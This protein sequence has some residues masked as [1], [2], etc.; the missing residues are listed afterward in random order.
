MGVDLQIEKHR[1]LYLFRPSRLI[2]YEK[3]AM[4]QNLLVPAFGIRADLTQHIHFEEIVAEVEE[5]NVGEGR[6]K[7]ESWSRQ[8][9]LLLQDILPGDLI[10]V[11][12]RNGCYGIAMARPECGLTEDGETGRKVEWL[13]RE[14]RKGVFRPDLEHS[15]GAQQSV[16][17]ITR[18]DAASR[19]MA[20]ISNGADPGP[21]AESLNADMSA[22]SI[23][24]YARMQMLAKIRTAFAGHGLAELVAALL[25]SDGY[26]CR[27]S[28]PGPDGGVDVLA[29]RGMTGLHDGLVVQVKSGDIVADAPTYRQLLGTMNGQGAVH[30]LLVAWAGV[31]RPVKSLVSESRFKIRVWDG[32]DVLDAVIEHYD[33]LPVSLR[34]KLGFR[35]LMIC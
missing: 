32:S 31:T 2:G 26:R 18:N 34:D 20:V 11:P 24:R 13:A 6:R 22:D 28:P 3:L 19:V 15:F 12:F 5:A 10:V 27:L 9:Y 4:D 1:A 7:I 16:C 23:E 30:G 25:E 17:Q 33:T 8:L 29:G 35:R 14:I 21:D